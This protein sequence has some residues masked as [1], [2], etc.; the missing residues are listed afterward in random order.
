VFNEFG[1]V[2]PGESSGDVT[3]SDR[4]TPVVAAQTP[5]DL[6]P[7]VATHCGGEGW[8]VDQMT[9]AP[10]AGSQVRQYRSSMDSKGGRMQATLTRPRMKRDEFV[11]VIHVPLGP[12]PVNATAHDRGVLQCDTDFTHM[13]DADV[14]EILA[15]R[16]A[17]L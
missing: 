11:A 5:R 4:N 1:H 12:L 7:Q 2:L 6:L 10:G 13:H 17:S 15:A 16:C 8:A 9:A 14:D 3:S